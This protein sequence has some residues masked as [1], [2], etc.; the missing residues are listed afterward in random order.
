MNVTYKGVHHD[1]P[2]KVQSKVDSKFAK[3]SKLLEKRG[4]REAH[5]VVGEQRGQVHAEITVQ[6]Y[7]HQLVSTG[8]GPDLFTA[9]SP[10][11]EKLEAQAIKQRS[12]WREKHRREA[13]P[14]AK[15]VPVA[16][17]KKAAAPAIRVN[18]VTTERRKPITLDEAILLLDGKKDY[19]VYRDASTERIAVLIRRSDGNLDLV[20]S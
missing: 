9:L 7:D 3:L 4:E 1:L 17:P 8:R 2:A 6:F 14:V 16:A 19:L 12:K 15:E 18:R 13:P 5:V 11:L 10:A 20:E